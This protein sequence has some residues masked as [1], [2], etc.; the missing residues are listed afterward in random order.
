M[1]RHDKSGAVKAM[2]VPQKG[3]SHEWVAD[4]MV[5]TIDMQWGVQKAIIKSDK[6]P[7]IKDLRC[8]IRDKRV[9]ET[10][11]ESAPKGEK[12]A[13]GLA[14]KAVRDVEGMISTWISATQERYKTNIRGEH[15]LLPW[16]ALRCG[17]AITNQTE[18]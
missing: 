12:Q 11:V 10:L 6:E 5:K 14:E 7:T 13:N 2:V 3:G 4:E 17:E 16:L 15:V 8:M 1:G 18:G 9:A